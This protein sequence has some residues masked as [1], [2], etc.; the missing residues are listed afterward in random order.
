MS[1]I[2]LCRIILS[3][4]LGPLAFCFPLCSTF[5][6]CWFY[7]GF[8]ETPVPTVVMHWFPVSPNPQTSGMETFHMICPSHSCLV[9]PCLGAS[10]D[11]ILCFLPIKHTAADKLYS[12]KKKCAPFHFKLF[13]HKW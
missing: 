9:E 3:M 12:S 5:L 2:L 4:R 11:G 6:V 7:D 1:G 13:F 8:S 10:T